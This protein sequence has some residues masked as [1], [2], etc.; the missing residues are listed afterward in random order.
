MTS[1]IQDTVAGGMTPA[2]LNVMR[3]HWIKT[4]FIQAGVLIF[5]G[6]V[7]WSAGAQLTSHDARGWNMVWGEALDASSALSTQI[8][9]VTLVAAISIAVATSSHRNT[10]VTELAQIRFSV[11]RNG[12][13]H[14]ANF[15]AAASVTVACAVT[16]A[17]PGRGTLLV[18]MSFVA[19]GLAVLIG[20]D[21]T[22]A[23]ISMLKDESVK[24]AQRAE[25]RIADA[26]SRI[27]A[28]ISWD[29]RWYSTALSAVAWVVVLWGASTLFAT[30]LLTVV[31]A[32]SPHDVVQPT[33][34]LR[35]SAR[36][37]T[38]VSLSLWIGYLTWVQAYGALTEHPWRL[39]LSRL[40]V[41]I[42]IPAGVLGSV[43]H[44][45]QVSWMMLAGALWLCLATG[46]VWL[47][48]LVLHRGRLGDPLSALLWRPV[49]WA[50]ERDSRAA[51]RRA[52]AVVAGSAATWFG[53][54]LKLNISDA[55]HM[56]RSRR[57]GA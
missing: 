55:G 53:T 56:D 29:A 17:E 26:R 49:T 21:K 50:L 25:M 30:G 34:F 4:A 10:E 43:F 12:M 15:S 44:G 33:A 36:T 47:L 40:A 27:L 31:A 28:P 8:A 52:E 14:L 9:C 38:F 45:D 24:R 6:L 51:Q 11:W 22:P 18:L 23:E 32:L 39:Q 54:P 35:L 3:R 42:L 57:R 7:A 20:Q 46:Q 1:R 37:A 16:L 5:A 13:T 48:A 2:Q 19:V 41:W